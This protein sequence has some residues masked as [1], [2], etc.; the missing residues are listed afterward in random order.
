MD[1]CSNVKYYLFFFLRHYPSGRVRPLGPVSD[2]LEHPQVYRSHLM[3]ALP[4]SPTFLPSPEKAFL[5]LALIHIVCVLG[6]VCLRERQM[7]KSG[8]VRT[9]SII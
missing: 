4:S 3:Q 5:F 8:Y 2:S 9:Y 1:V 7:E 6:G